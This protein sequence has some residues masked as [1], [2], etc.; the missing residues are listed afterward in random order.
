[1]VYINLLNLE[2]LTLFQAKTVQI[3]STPRFRPLKLFMTSSENWP[4]LRK[5]TTGV[6]NIYLASIKTHTM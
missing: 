4:F 2:T 1:M 3:V 5:Q 6:E